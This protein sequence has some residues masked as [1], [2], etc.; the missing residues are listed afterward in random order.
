MIDQIK[1]LPDKS[2]V[3]VVTGDIIHQGNAEASKR[4]TLFFKDLYEVVKQ[5]VCAIYLVP[6]NHDKK[7]TTENEFLIPAYRMMN[8]KIANIKKES[9]FDDVF[10]D[11]FWKYQEESYGAEK[12]SGYLEFSKEIY[13]IFGKDI[14]LEDKY[15]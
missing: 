13:K 9:K 12:G 15:N 6:G 2:M 8:S 7:R 5:K 1:I 11:S 14:E 10:Y 4:A 3:I